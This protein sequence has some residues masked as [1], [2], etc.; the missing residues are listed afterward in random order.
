MFLHIHDQLTLNEVQERFAECFPSLKL[1]FYSESHKRFEPTDKAYQLNNRLRMGDVRRNHQNGSLE[2]KSW[3][4]V[5]RVERELREGYGLNAQVF[6][7]NRSG[8]WVQTS[9]SDSLTLAE[10][11]ALGFNEKLNEG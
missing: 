4:T 2:I 10:Q 7:C 3:Y 8:D 11:S 9:L 1:E 6:R 5:A